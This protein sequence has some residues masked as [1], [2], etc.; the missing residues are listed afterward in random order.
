MSAKLGPSGELKIAPAE[1]PP[2]VLALLAAAKETGEDEPSGD[3]DVDERV[4]A[5]RGTIAKW[6]A[7]ER[8]Q[9]VSVWKF[10][11]LEAE[12]AARVMAEKGDE[13]RAAAYRIRA[14]IYNDVARKTIAGW[15]RDPKDGTAVPPEGSEKPL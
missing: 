9:I 7:W 12:E 8:E 5:L 15:N 3:P 11:A 4:G 14:S 6:M 13:N 10:T 2:E 1:K